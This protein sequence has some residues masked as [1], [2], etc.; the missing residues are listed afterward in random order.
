MTLR[1]IKAVAVFCGSNFGASEEF[2]DGAGALGQALGKAGITVVYGGTTK[3]LMGIVADAALEAG[4]SVHGVI[5]A[6]LHQRGHSHSGL[7][8]HEIAET[9]GRR[10]ERMVELA[11]AFIALPGG[12]GTVEELMEVWTMNQLAE[13]DKPVGLLNAAEFFSRFLDFIDHM[14]DTRFLPAAHRRAICVDT[15]A[16]ALIEK[17][18]NYVRVDVP[19]WL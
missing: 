7:T 2:A 18:H 9:L 15:D 10:K 11:D 3:G 12:I 13:I 19:K 4:G 1:P 5:T 16:G 17:L 6:S 14:V 8:I